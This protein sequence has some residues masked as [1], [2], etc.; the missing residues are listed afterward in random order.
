MASQV[1]GPVPKSHS[2]SKR[3]RPK[4]QPEGLSFIRKLLHHP[5]IEQAAEWVKDQARLTWDREQG[6][7]LAQVSAELEKTEKD[8]DTAQ[9]SL[10]ELE[11][12]KA[13][14]PRFIK[15]SKV[16]TGKDDTVVPFKDWLRRDQIL[17]WLLVAFIGVCMAMG[18]SNV[19]SNLLASGEAVFIE[20]P[21]LAAALAALSPLASISVKWM[22]HFFRYDKSRRRYAIT[23]FLTTIAILALWTVLFVDSFPGVA[24]PVLL[25]MEGGFD[26]GPLLTWSQLA[27][28]ILVAACL[29]L[30]AE[31]I[32]IKYA[33]GWYV[34][35]LEYLELNKAI[36]RVKPERDA[37]HQ[38]RSALV[39]RKSELEASR[40][41]FV[42]D[43]MAT[44]LAEKARFTA[45]FNFND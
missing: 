22:T 13:N 25:D 37:L 30:A 40:Q 11:G 4:K 33:P 23:V 15:S 24:S 6:A 12:H 28:E 27:L 34:E 41:A 19:Y 20:T 21:W 45:Q 32:W 14:T 44:F 18:W 3:G 26:T 43:Q 16:N 2:A 7:E 5:E 35:S 10:D 9:Q 42:N 29:W 17:I 31:D 38:R 1:L 39:G 8:L 36:D